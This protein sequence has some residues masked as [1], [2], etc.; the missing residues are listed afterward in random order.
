MRELIPQ[1]AH[2]VGI[3]APA[4]PPIRPYMVKS[5]IVIAVL[6]GVFGL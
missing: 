5:K 3:H 6:F 1:P 2:G 4:D